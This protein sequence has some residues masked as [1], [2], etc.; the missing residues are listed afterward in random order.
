M[1]TLPRRLP[2]HPQPRVG[3][4]LSSWLMRLAHANAQ[5]LPYFSDQVTGEMNFWKRDPDWAVAE[6]VLPALM[7]ASGL[8]EAALREMMLPR[9]AGVLFERLSLKGLS[10]WVLPYTRRFAV[11]QQSG[12]V[13]CPRCLDDLAGPYLRLNWRLRFLIVCPEHGV[14]LRERCP[15]CDAFFAPHVNNLKP[16]QDW[17][18]ATRLSFGTCFHCQGDVRQ[19]SEGADQEVDPLDLAF[20]ARLHTALD[21]GR[22]AWDN[23][24]HVPSLEGFEVLRRLLGVLCL[25]DPGGRSPR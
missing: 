12:S 23:L 14:M 17:S 22:L 13:Y 10:G 8:S 21:T 20:Q 24:G 5:Q 7:T 6:S 3:E 15:H 25:A 16:D 19:G 4:S 2:R 18:Q 1:T 11:T 9:F